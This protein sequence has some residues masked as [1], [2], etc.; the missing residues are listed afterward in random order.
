MCSKEKLAVE[1]WKNNLKGWMKRVGACQSA[2]DND[3]DDEW[4]CSH[5]TFGFI[6]ISCMHMS[7]CFAWF[8]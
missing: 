5:I 3:D 8:R 4:H 7:E 6:D 1:A 2:T